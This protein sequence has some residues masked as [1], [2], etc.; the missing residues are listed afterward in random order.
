MAGQVVGSRGLQFVRAA[1]QVIEELA[2]ITAVH[3]RPKPALL[4]AMRDQEQRSSADLSAVTVVRSPFRMLVLVLL[5]V[6]I[7]L[8]VV[9]LHDMWRSHQDER[10][11]IARTD[12]YMPL[13]RALTNLAAP[14]GMTP[15]TRNHRA[16]TAVIAGFSWEGRNV[17]PEGTAKAFAINLRAIG[18]APT[19]GRCMT[20]SDGVVCRVDFTLAGRPSTVWVID[21]T[22]PADSPTRA[23]ISPDLYFPPPARWLSLPAF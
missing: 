21:A 9:G 15:A 7:S 12:P 5:V 4:I 2:A 23:S 3:D 17:S 11:F 22:R 18:A 6:G 20:R 10:R 19:V 1:G 13:A 14:S 16:R 8:G